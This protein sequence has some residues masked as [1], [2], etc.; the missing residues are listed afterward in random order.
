[1]ILILNCNK[2]FLSAYELEYTG[3][4]KLWDS[5]LSLKNKKKIH[6]RNLS[7]KGN[8]LVQACCQEV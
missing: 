5:S 4:M 3:K 6:Q 8:I 7:E 1:M 2:L